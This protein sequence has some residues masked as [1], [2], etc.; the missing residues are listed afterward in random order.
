MAATEVRAPGVG[1]GVLAQLSRIRLAVVHIFLVQPRVGRVLYSRDGEGLPGDRAD[2]HLPGSC[3]GSRHVLTPKEGVPGGRLLLAA[4]QKDVSTRISQGEVA[5]TAQAFLPH[6]ETQGTTTAAHLV[7]IIRTWGIL[8]HT[9]GAPS[10]GSRQTRLTVGLPHGAQA[11]LLLSYTANGGLVIA[12]EWHINT[13]VILC[14]PFLPS[15][16]A[17][18]H[19][20]IMD[21]TFNFAV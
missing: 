19:Q 17:A 5:V 12:E 16:T 10:S 11:A 15:D 21:P 4:G 3:G 13:V 14:G 6:P 7:G 20:V 18:L 8:V 9:A 2:E 1:A